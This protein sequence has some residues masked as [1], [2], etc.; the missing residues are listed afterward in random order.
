MSGESNKKIEEV[1]LPVVT[2]SSTAAPTTS[3][4]AEIVMDGVQQLVS[5]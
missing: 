5:F 2:A 4:A 3:A 1:T